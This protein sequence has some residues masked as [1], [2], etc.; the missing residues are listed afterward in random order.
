MPEKSWFSE[1]KTGVIVGVVVGVVLLVGIIVTVVLVTKSGGSSSPGNIPTN[2][3]SIADTQQKSILLPGETLDVG[4]Q[5]IGSDPIYTSFDSNTFTAY[6]AVLGI[7]VTGAWTIKCDFIYFAEDGGAILFQYQG[8]TVYTINPPTPWPAVGLTTSGTSLIAYTVKNQIYWRADV[9]KDP[10]YV[11][12][13]G[14]AFNAVEPVNVQTYSTNATPVYLG[15]QDAC[16]IS[17]QLNGFSAY[18]VDSSNGCYAGYGSPAKESPPVYT[19]NFIRTV[20]RL[21]PGD[22]LN[23]AV[24]LRRTELGKDILVFI[25]TSRGNVYGYVSYFDTSNTFNSYAN[26]I[27]SYN[28][29]IDGNAYKLVVGNNILQ[30]MRGST[31]V[32]ALDSTSDWEFTQVIPVVDENNIVSLRVD[33]KGGAVF[34]VKAGQVYETSIGN[35][36][37]LVEPVLMNARPAYATLLGTHVG[38]RAVAQYEGL[39]RYY[40]DSDERCWAWPSYTQNVSLDPNQLTGQ[41]YTSLV[42]GMQ[43]KLYERVIVGNYVMFI[44]N[45]SRTFVVFENDVLVWQ[46]PPYANNESVPGFVFNSNMSSGY[47]LQWQGETSWGYVGGTSLQRSQSYTGVTFENG[48]AT[49]VAADGRVVV[50]Y[51]GTTVTLAD[52]PSTELGAP[53]PVYFGV[54][55]S[56]N[57][58]ADIVAREMG[59]VSNPSAY[60]DD[61]G[62]CYGTYPNVPQTVTDFADK[63]VDQVVGLPLAPT[64]VQCPW[65]EDDKG[66]RWMVDRASGHL[67]K[68]PPGSN[69]PDWS[70][71]DAGVAN[72]TGGDRYAIFD[73]NGG[74]QLHSPNGTVVFGAAQASVP[75]NKRGFDGSNDPTSAFYGRSNVAQALYRYDTNGTLVN[76]PFV[77]TQWWQTIGTSAAGF[78]EGWATY[79]E[80]VMDTEWDMHVIQL[81]AGHKLWLPDGSMDSTGARYKTPMSEQVC[82]DLGQLYGFNHVYLQNGNTCL[83]KYNVAGLE[84]F[85]TGIPVT[86]NRIVATPTINK[87]TYAKYDVIDF[88]GDSQNVGLRAYANPSTGRVEV[89]DANDELVW[90]SHATK[91]KS[92]NMSHFVFNEG[93]L[94]AVSAAG[95]TL[96]PLRNGSTLNFAPFKI[97]YAKFVN[98]PNTVE[99]E[100][101]FYDADGNLFASIPTAEVSAA[102]TVRPPLY[103]IPSN[104]GTEGKCKQILPSELTWDT[105]KQLLRVSTNYTR[106]QAAGLYEGFTNNAG[107]SSF[108]AFWTTADGVTG[109]CYG[110]MGVGTITVSSTWAKLNN[111]D[112]FSKVTAYCTETAYNAG[113]CSMFLVGTSLQAGQGLQSSSGVWA[114]RVASL[115]GV[116]FYQRIDENTISEAAKA[117]FPGIN[118]LALEQRRLV[119]KNT[120]G[121]E[122]W[123]VR[124]PEDTPPAYNMVVTDGGDLAVL[125]YAQQIIWSWRAGLGVHVVPTGNR[126][127]YVTNK[128]TEETNSPQVAISQDI[129]VHIQHLIAII[130]KAMTNTRT[131]AGQAGISG[132][133][134]DSNY[135]R[136]WSDEPFA[137]NFGDGLLALYADTNRYNAV[138]GF[139]PTF[140]QSVSSSGTNMITSDFPIGLEWNA[141]ALVSGSVD[142]STAVLLGDMRSNEQSDCQFIAIPEG[143]T[144][145]TVSNSKCYGVYGTATSYVLPNKFTPYV[146]D[147]VSSLSDG[148]SIGPYTYTDD[149]GISRIGYGVIRADGSV[150][151]ANAM[152][153]DG[154]YR[155][156]FHPFTKQ[157]FVID[158]Y[159]D[160][161]NPVATYTFDSACTNTYEAATLKWLPDNGGL[162]IE[163][164]DGTA[165]GTQSSPVHNPL[166]VT[167]GDLTVTDEGLAST[168][169]QLRRLPNESNPS[170]VNALSAVGF[171]YELMSMDDSVVAYPFATGKLGL[172]ASNSVGYTGDSPTALS[173]NI[174]FATDANVYSGAPF[175][176]YI[177]ISDV[178]RNNTGTFMKADGTIIESVTSHCS[179]LAGY[180]GGLYG[181]ARFADS[182]SVTVGTTPA[183]RFACVFVQ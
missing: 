62:N 72:Y 172:Q 34:S 114:V 54:Q 157:L 97:N 139:L 99:Y 46:S 104:Y 77:D 73:I 153:Q 158:K 171:A 92:R 129:T 25:D 137:M 173:N 91:D 132:A 93:G 48:T 151:S 147:T 18:V 13:F 14:G 26:E 88:S 176:K 30:I 52:A 58:C 135:V 128:P 37:A 63:Y 60:L 47:V 90:V 155:V 115:L 53:G 152:L 45:T 66:Y 11:S 12:V 131:A 120:A 130:A 134:L 95:T 4:A 175:S 40:Y 57:A 44:D 136:F 179:A 35:A 6:D 165:N 96:W 84:I 61:V 27:Y 98:I 112:T 126:V 2:I 106:C 127:I 144:T 121:D 101:Q 76:E 70:T 50:T 141:A 177:R 82:I 107:L 122:I 21:V 33:S 69:R 113:T 80:T 3:N 116:A 17:A 67:V 149:A 118:E 1:H 59:Y 65:W 174:D 123:Y 8:D 178:Y 74:L 42:P 181:A 183:Q 102:G 100:F 111:F 138:L 133:L 24:A 83:A 55:S 163:C 19:G 105:P 85:S 22:T 86:A 51:S 146:G 39:D 64:A 81:T 36:P 41:V 119:A 145:F 125:D 168:Y 94:A 124:F 159:V 166:S 109:D 71:Y 68:Y 10:E 78:V 148:D 167:D 43:V 31:V 108:S 161:T 162:F 7:P 169:V 29:P 142:P 150:A 23:N 49:V 56:S 38:C 20:E 87:P 16:K 140:H 143:F 9:G 28:G 110:N 164:S 154:E 180:T 103:V 117:E 15:V 79:G 170:N 5:G 160:D 32:A 75:L 89:Y 156:Y 182:V